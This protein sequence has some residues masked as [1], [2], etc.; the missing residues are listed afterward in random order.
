MRLCTFSLLT[1]TLGVILVPEIDAFW[2]KILWKNGPD[3]QTVIDNDFTDLNHPNPAKISKTLTYPTGAYKCS[4]LSELATPGG[5]EDPIPGIFTIANSPVLGVDADYLF[6]YENEKC[7]RAPAAMLRLL[8]PPEKKSEGGNIWFFDLMDRAF[9]QFKSWKQLDPKNSI[10]K[11]ILEWLRESEKD[12]IKSHSAGYFWMTVP[13][14]GGNMRWGSVVKTIAIPLQAIKNSDPYKVSRSLA[15]GLKQ[16][17]EGWW[18]RESEHIQEQANL[19]T[20]FSS[21]DFNFRPT[22]YL[23]GDKVPTYMADMAM[24]R[25]TENYNLYRAKQR[26]IQE[27]HKNRPVKEQQQVSNTQGVPSDIRMPASLQRGD[28]GMMIEE[29]RKE[30]DMSGSNKS[31]PNMPKETPFQLQPM[32]TPKPQSSGSNSQPYSGYYQSYIP[33]NYRSQQS[34][35]LGELKASEPKQLQQLYPNYSYSVS[36]QHLPR[37]NIGKVEQSNINSRPSSNTQPNPRSSQN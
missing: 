12:R 29:I 14:Q 2:M 18:A 4:L 24:E 34:Q 32:P 3:G 28:A 16:S 35:M 10:D 25:W 33:F 27:A 20:D 11:K 23:T 13:S 5:P 21:V 26:A 1:T 37:Y 31:V 8:V 36:Q 17:Y 9:P 6:F 15:R 7:D 22:D 30:V 19:N